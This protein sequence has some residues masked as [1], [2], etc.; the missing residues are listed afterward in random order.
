MDAAILGKPPPSVNPEKPPAPIF[1]FRPPPC[2]SAVAPVQAACYRSPAMPPR[3]SSAAQPAA[4]PRGDARVHVFYGS[5]DFAAQKAADALL[6]TLCPE[7]ERDFG[8]EL[9]APDTPEPTA[10]ASAALLERTLGALLTPSFLGGSKTVYLRNAPF[11]EPR[12]E[13]GKFADVK[14]RVERLTDLLKKGL[15][16]DIHFVLVT[17]GLDKTTSFYKTLAKI[18]DLHEFKLAEYERDAQ[19]SFIPAVKAA[20]DAEQLKMSRDVFD[21][22]VDR[23]G[24]SIRQALSE[25][26]KLSIYLGTE[27]RA[28]TLADLQL[29]VA[30]AREAKP[31]DFADAYCTGSVEAALRAMHRLLFQKENPVT[32]LVLLE[33][34]LR[35][36]VLFADAIARGW[37]KLGGRAEWPSI[38][39]QN[40]LPPDAEA[41]LSALA[42]DP[43]KIN[44]PFRAARL[45]SAAH[46]FTASYWF[47]WLNAAVD[48]H[49]AMTGDSSIPPETS[50]ELFVI[51]TIG[52]LSRAAR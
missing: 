50:L 6:D 17:P 34:R 16:P 5:D 11:F 39:W 27:R 33:G 3:K 2:A 40:P 31:W 28:V 43:R 47:R 49:A 9:I 35:E 21:A 13:P 46:R 18:A 15:P 20:L 42:T 22:F 52:A 19:Q 12:S 7:A 37:A 36:M 26:E 30:P 29:M 41:A 14:A 1:A 48:A 44:P 51:R 38:F 10:D 8:L 32:L 25:I 45:A 24:Y 4:A 23:T